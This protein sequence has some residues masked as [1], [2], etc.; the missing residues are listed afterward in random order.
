MNLFSFRVGASVGLLLAFGAAT[1]GSA[2]A[3]RSTRNEP[4]AIQGAA[5]STRIPNTGAASTPIPDTETAPRGGTLPD[6]IAPTPPH[7]FVLTTFAGN[8]T[9]QTITVLWHPE[10]SQDAEEC[11]TVMWM[12]V[13]AFLSNVAEATGMDRQLMSIQPVTPLRLRVTASDISTRAMMRVIAECRPVRP[14]SPHQM[15]NRLRGGPTG[16]RT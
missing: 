14:A 3:Q 5:P 9:S 4:Q 6:P 11:T 13:Q 12:E 8:G 15:M 10:V 16:H 2:Q 1:F 7:R